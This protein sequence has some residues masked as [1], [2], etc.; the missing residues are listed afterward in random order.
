MSDTKQNPRRPGIIGL[1]HMTFQASDVEKALAYYRDI[2]GYADQLRLTDDDGS[3]GR[4]FVRINDVQWIELRPQ[5][6]PKTDRLIQFGLQVEDA[7][8]M[9]A[10][11]ASRGIAFSSLTSLGAI[12]NRAFHVK[13][14][15]GHTVEFV[16]C[17]PEGWLAR[18][19]P[20][21]AREPA[22]C[23][24][25]SCTSGSTSPPWRSRWPSIATPSNAP[26]PGAGAATSRRRSIGLEV[27]S[28]PAA[29]EEVSRRKEGRS[30]SPFHHHQ[31]SAR[32]EP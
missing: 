22:S 19:R 8:A 18:A 14:P 17:L 23:H 4:A 15:D 28:V 6:A 7:E 31:I 26:S 27:P 20:G 3:V 13:D 24:T 32:R 2:L 11:L 25:V 21:R 10:N 1:S 29:M 30:S 12:G 5:S 16:Q 9:R